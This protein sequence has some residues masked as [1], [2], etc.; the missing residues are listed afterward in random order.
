VADLLGTGVVQGGAVT[1]VMAIVVLILRGHLVPA[2]VLR[3]LRADRD[4]RIAEVAA[5]RDTWRAAHQI[6][7]EARH[8]AQAQV[9][10]LLELSRTADHVLRSLP[11]SPEEV[12]SGP[13]GKKVA[14]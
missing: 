13:K 11:R 6:S 8:T 1:V 10:E 5:E 4:A 3:D 7:E 9:G 14:P 2:S 12:A